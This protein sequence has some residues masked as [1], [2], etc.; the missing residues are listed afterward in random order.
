MTRLALA[1]VITLALA[2]PAAAQVP[3]DAAKKAAGQAT[4]GKLE[5]EI[6]RRLLEEGRKNQCSFKTDTDQLEPGCDQ[7]MKRLSN[8]LVDA[9]KRLNGAGVKNFKFVVSGHT[10]TSGSAAHNQELSARRAAVIEKELVARG[11]PQGEIE[12]VG[13]GS[14][15]PLV[16]P[17]DTPA[18]KAKNRRYELQVRL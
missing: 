6:N 4:V 16:K 9:K 2:A 5:K 18:K 12:S 3:W 8:A 11:I 1:A 10:D 13:M 17:D 15:K 14:K 7:K